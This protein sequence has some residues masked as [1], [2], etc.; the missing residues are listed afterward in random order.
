[1]AAKKE[2]TCLQIALCTVNENGNDVPHLVGLFEDGSIRSTTLT[3]GQQAGRRWQLITR[4]EVSD[5]LSETTRTTQNGEGPVEISLT[6]VIGV[7]GDVT[8]SRDIK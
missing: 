6:P 3:P 7:G 5:E 1:M 2:L 4:P 8:R